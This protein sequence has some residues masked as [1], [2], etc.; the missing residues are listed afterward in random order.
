MP[1]QT[2]PSGQL[3]QADVLWRDLGIEAANLL[4]LPSNSGHL[5]PFGVGELNIKGDVLKRLRRLW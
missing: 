4:L 2:F 3:W 1:G 5:K